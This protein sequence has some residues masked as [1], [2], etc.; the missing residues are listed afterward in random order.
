MN[1]IKHMVYDTLRLVKNDV[2]FYGVVASIVMRS[3]VF[4]FY[5]SGI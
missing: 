5:L 2:L 4:C 3:L 1:N